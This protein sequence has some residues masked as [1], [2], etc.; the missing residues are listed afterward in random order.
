MPLLD[1]KAIL[2][3]EATNKTF[4][5]VEKINVSRV[6][7]QHNMLLKSFLVLYVKVSVLLEMRRLHSRDSA[8]LK[9]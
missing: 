9:R 4:R 7:C 8:H 2:K 6:G 5:K 1:S 3:P